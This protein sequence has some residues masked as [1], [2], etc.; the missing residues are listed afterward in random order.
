MKKHLTYIFLI[1]CFLTSTA[2]TIDKAFGALYEYDYFK[3][4][5]LFYTQLK[6]SRVEAS[7]GLA[8]IYYR[9]DNPFYKLDSAYKYIAICRSNFANL[10][11]EKKEK[12]KTIYHLTDSSIIALHDS[13]SQKAYNIFFKN[14]AIQSAEKYATTFFYSNYIED[15]LCKRDSL[16]FNEIKNS[17]QS[18]IITNT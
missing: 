12:L 2:S 3:A 11:I 6:K 8:T 15:V 9:N 1:S 4:K 5:K 18:A 10:S 7:F 14:I 16:A 13:I 17:L